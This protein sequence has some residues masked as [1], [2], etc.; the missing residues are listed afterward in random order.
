MP[1]TSAGYLTI[2]IPLYR[3]SVPVEL[4]R[5]VSIKPTLV[6]RLV[7]NGNA[8][9]GVIK[10]EMPIFHPLGQGLCKCKI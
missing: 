4:R 5:W 10:I 6:Q 1:S 9:D 2:I 8:F 7:Y 3:V